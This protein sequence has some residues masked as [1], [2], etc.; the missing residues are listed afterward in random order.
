MKERQLPNSIDTERALLGSLIIDPE[1]IV[2]VADRLVPE[3]FYREGHQVL[4][5]TILGLYEKEI[6]AEYVTICETL[7]RTHKNH[8]INGESLD[9][10]LSGLVGEV[11]TSGNTVYYADIVIDHAT[12]R[13]LIRAGGEI[14]ASAYQDEDVEQV[15]Q[16]AESLIYGINQDQDHT[17]FTSVSTIIDDYLSKLWSK[18]SG[19]EEIGL[20]T[21]LTDLDNI[22][23]GGLQKT[24]LT[25][26]A[27]RPAMG[28][29][30][31]AL[32][33]A[34]NIFQKGGHVAIFS[35]EM[36]K[37]QL[38][39]R[40]LSQQ[41]HI[42]SMRLHRFQIHDDEYERL[43]AARAKL[44][45][46]DL[47]TIDDTG[48]ITLSAMRSKLRRLHARMPV[49]LLI[50][51]YIQ[52]MGAPVD[53]SRKESNRVVEIGHNTMGLKNIA[54][55][56]D[57]PVLA[58]AQLSRAVESR[59]SKVPQLSDLR[60]SG[61]IENDA[62]IVMFIYRDEVYNP[63]TERK[64]TADIIVAKHRNGP[65]GEVLLGFKAQ[66]TWFHNLSEEEYS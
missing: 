57:I 16:R 39:L 55:E 30:S 4:Y 52:L 50:V 36:S 21:G 17:D 47:L 11:P 64:G 53:G 46:T 65:T 27:A 8:Q 59:K 41:T 24:D 28:K 14:V 13:R 61:S 3:H 37:E 29:S 54:K 20:K 15:V 2:L 12:R 22:F 49:D 18:K 34:N 31:L 6:P 43:V 51:D 45:S 26:L 44:A 66:E 5:K 56:F 62:D 63:E 40:L 35:L 42:D 19:G 25:I 48:G 38:G 7:D 10:Y 58:L 33:I 9:A 1:A 60:E 23:N 32:T